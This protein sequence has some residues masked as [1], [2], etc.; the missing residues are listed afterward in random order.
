MDFRQIRYF[1]AVASAGSFS[2]ASRAINVTQSALSQQIKG[3][4]EDLGTKLFERSPSGVFLTQSGET[5]QQY[6]QEIFALSERARHETLLT[7]GKIQGAVS[8]ALSSTMADLLL[9]VLLKQMQSEC[10]E[11]QLNVVEGPSTQTVELLENSRIDLGIVPEHNMP[12]N[13]DFVRCMRKRLQFFGSRENFDLPAGRGHSI[14]LKDAAKFPL[15]VFSKHPSMRQSIETAAAQR[16]IE[17]VFKFESSLASIVRSYVIGGLACAIL[18]D[19]LFHNT[20]LKN[21]FCALDV[22]N[23]YVERAYGI[24]SPRARPPHRPARMV[25]N[26][27]IKILEAKSGTAVSV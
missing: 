17:I 7:E 4:E 22:V 26:M 5:F 15:A 21:D 2:R 13:I 19:F 16:G 23:P 8:I 12:S 10:P 20:A 27:L 11:V 9:P 1:L 14:D 3:L 25:K 18:P 6:A 24:G